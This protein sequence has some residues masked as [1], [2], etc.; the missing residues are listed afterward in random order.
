MD[1]TAHQKERL[2]KLL[3]DR[4][5]KILDLEMQCVETIA[6]NFSSLNDTLFGINI[7]MILTP[8]FFF[9]RLDNVQNEKI[10]L[11]RTIAQK[12]SEYE[13]ATKRY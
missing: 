13:A 5:K 1:E 7:T 12:E 9:W 10:K 6:H 11:E 2:T 3:D 4:S 8:L